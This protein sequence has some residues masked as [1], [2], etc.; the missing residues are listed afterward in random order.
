LMALD[1]L[2]R[3]APSDAERFEYDNLVAIKRAEARNL[4]PSAA[5]L[6]SYPGKYGI[7]SI[8]ADGGQLF[9]QRENGPK[10]RLVP[11]SDRSFVID[12]AGGSVTFTTGSDGRVDGFTLVR[13]AGD[14]VRCPRQ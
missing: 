3:T 7:R 13:S 5:M 2:A 9:F 10:M 6:D 12:Q 4:K 1:T 8:T 14:T 11:T